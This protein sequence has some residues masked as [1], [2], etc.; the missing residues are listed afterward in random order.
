MVNQRGLTNY[1]SISSL[2]HLDFLL[3]R[4]LFEHWNLRYDVILDNNHDH[5]WV[6]IYIIISTFFLF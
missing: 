4:I 1:L 6:I 2:A 3:Q 5:H